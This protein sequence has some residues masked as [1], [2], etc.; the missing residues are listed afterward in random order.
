MQKSLFIQYVDKLMKG[1]TSLVEKING[2]NKDVTY[3]H[4][5]MLRK[6]YSADQKWET[7]AVDTTFVTADMVAMDSPLPLKMRD[8]VSQAGGDLPKIGIKRVLREKQINT[9]NIMI[10]QGAGE[11]QVVAKLANDL[12]ACS[13]GIDEKNEANFLEAISNGV[14]AIEDIEK[15]GLGFRADFGYLPENQFGVEKKGVVSYE[16]IKRVLEYA[17]AKGSTID[18]IMISKT[19]YDKVRNQRWA[20]EL[21]ANYNGQVY[22]DSTNLP[23]PSASK[24]NDA[25]ADDNNGVKFLVVDRTVIEERNGKRTAR[26]PFN[27]NK[28]VFLVSEQVGALVWSN[29]AEKTNPVEGV[30]YQVVDGYKLLAKYSVNEPALQELTTGQAL[31]L[32]VIEGVDQIFTLDITDVDDSAQTEGDE[33][34]NYDGKSYNKQAVIGTYNALE[35]VDALSTEISDAELLK[36]I[37]GLS[38][39]KA[40]KLFAGLA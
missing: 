25:F 28:M 36:A 17:D 18:T 19:L 40:T 12:V 7:A 9:L 38:K 6:E 34:F 35:G 29:C 30:K 14:V 37:N 23:T 10:A 4:K 24:F 33:N 8:T 5:T 22:G 31:V 27:A 2:R 1:F 32:P 16:D 21:V 15:T 20:K 13:K 3:L 26:K 39:A 11:K